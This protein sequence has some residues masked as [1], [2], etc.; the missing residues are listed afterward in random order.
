MNCEIAW[1]GRA[2]KEFDALPEIVRE[3]IFSALALLAIES[4][5]DVRPLHGRE[6]MFR[7]RVGEYRV[8]FVRVGGTL[9]VQR[10][11]S[12]GSAYKE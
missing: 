8:L 9:V 3:R 7:L 6:G 2:A 12:R 5:G 11:A 4:R 10:V 1:E